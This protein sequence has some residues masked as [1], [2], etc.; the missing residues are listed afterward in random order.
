MNPKA[1]KLGREEDIFTPVKVL[2]D[3][4]MRPK[5]LDDIIKRIEEYDN[6]RKRNNG[7]VR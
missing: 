7:D 6:E 4:I 2:W 3:K 5:I 1:N